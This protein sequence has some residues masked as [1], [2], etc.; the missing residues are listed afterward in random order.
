MNVASWGNR[1]A[2]LVARQLPLLWIVLAISP[3]LNPARSVWILVIVYILLYGA[4]T[5]FEAVFNLRRNQIEKSTLGV[6]FIAA[7]LYCLAAVFS[8]LQVGVV[9]FVLVSIYGIASLGMDVF[10]LS[11]SRTRIVGKAV[12]EGIVSLL[13]IYVGINNFSIDNA[14]R[15]A[16]IV[17]GL[18]VTLLLIAIDLAEGETLASLR[19]WVALALFTAAVVAV[20]IY[21]E[22]YLQDRYRWPVLSLLFALAVAYFFF[23]WLIRIK[24]LTAR[25][26]L[27]FW[28]YAIVLNAYF[29]Y[30]FTDYTHILQLI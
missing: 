17:P 9:L 4:V 19:Y 7:G 20:I 26:T 1:F 6:W 3:N 28:L 16:V 12:L 18:V 27:L 2:I 30:L 29:F 22:N 8:A 13:I 5:G 14:W 21:L 15:L 24:L 10:F 11:H 23:P 25:Q